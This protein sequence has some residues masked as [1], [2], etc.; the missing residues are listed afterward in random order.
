MI[1]EMVI[2]ELYDIGRE[3]YRTIA[4]DRSEL[5]FDALMTTVDEPD[6]NDFFFLALGYIDA[7]YDVDTSQA[8]IDTYYTK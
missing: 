5:L 1:S 7:N 6:Q 3:E 4:V 2:S 8:K